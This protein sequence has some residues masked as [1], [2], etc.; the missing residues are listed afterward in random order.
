[1]AIIAILIGLL[2]PAVQKVREAAARS[3]SMNN[4]KQMSLALHNMNDSYSVLPAMGGNY[5][6]AGASLGPANP[7]RGTVQFFLLPFIEQANAQTSMAANHP[8]S[9]W[10]GYGISTYANP[11]DASSTFPSPL[12]SSSPRFE[13]GYAPNEWVFG[14][15]NAPGN[16]QISDT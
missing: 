14:S 7:M 5:P 10:C 12:D 8:D 4:L 16:V 2:L 9:W 13:T 1:I 3:K 15:G 11:A 6:R